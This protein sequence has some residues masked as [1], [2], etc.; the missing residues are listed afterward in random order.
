MTDALALDRLTKRF[1]GVL[2]L[3]ELSITV[4][5]GEVRAVVGE[6]GAGKSTFVKTLAGYHRPDSGGARLW[7]KEISWPVA[8]PSEHGI[9][10]LHQDLALAED[11]TVAENISLLSGR[12]KRLLLPTARKEEAAVARQLAERFDQTFNVRQK[13]GRLTP[14]EKA[15]VAVL[16]AIR[17]L[18][19]RGHARSLVILDEPFAALF[20]D[21]VRRLMRFIRG[22]IEDGSSVILID[23]HLEHVLDVADSV[24]V[25]RNGAA[26]GTYK[27]ETVDSKALVNLMLG[28]ELSRPSV[29][30]EQASP[31]DRADCPRLSVKGLAG[32]SVRGLTLQVGAGE[33]VGLTGL[34]GMGSEDVPYLIAGTAPSQRGDVHVDGIEVSG[35]P[36][37]RR[38][39]GIVLVPGS[40]ASGLWLDGSAME[41]VLLPTAREHM[42]RFGFRRRQE[43]AAALELM[44]RFEV[45]PPD[46]G[47][48]L[49]AFS[50]GNQQKLLIAK[51]LQVNPRVLL[52]HGPSHGVDAGGRQ[53]VHAMIRGA[54]ADGAAVVVASD[55][56][57]EL[58]QLCSRVLIFRD[59]R[60]ATVLTGDGI[61]EPEILAKREKKVDQ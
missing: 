25:L 7:G 13:V 52:I 40:R 44:R 14:A 4:E 23:H 21:E 30:V 9:A 37:E 43:K 53:A 33:I 49:A 15:M 46:P 1:A 3:N 59:G 54:A 16:R 32:R 61:N 11:L 19:R 22:V 56:A 55:D 57:E 60:V 36:P 58:T 27:A 34:T 20:G 28:Y 50:G 42:K 6:N 10:V 8:D 45:H 5:S 17:E 39:G 31:S 47:L 38:R 48:K 51:W 18:D 2:A 29:A 41:N 12:G 24:T 35:R 26:V